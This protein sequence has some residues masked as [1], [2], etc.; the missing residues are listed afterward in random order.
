MKIQ[1]FEEETEIDICRMRF[2]ADLSASDMRRPY[3]PRTD[4]E[5]VLCRKFCHHLPASSATEGSITDINSK[6]TAS[7]LVFN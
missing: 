5:D 2:N 6:V 3:L 7:R 4:V 1:K